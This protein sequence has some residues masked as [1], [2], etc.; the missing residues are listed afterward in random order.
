MLSKQTNGRTTM[1]KAKLGRTG[2][3]IT[4]LGLG[5]LPMGRAQANLSVDDGARVIRHAIDKGINFIDTAAS[6]GTYE[7]I[8]E[9]LKGYKG[10][11]IVASKTQA[12]TYEE[13]EE[14]VKD[15]LATLD[16]DNLDI[17][18][19]HAA[20]SVDPFRE[21]AEC[22]RYLIDSKRSGLVKAIGISTHVVDVVREALKIPEIDIIHPLINKASLGILGGSAEDM[23]N[24]AKEAH[25]AGKGI[26]VMKVYAGGHLTDDPVGAFTYLL[27]K[28]YLDA[29]VVGML[30]PEEVEI[31]LCIVEGRNP[32]YESVKAI[33]RTTK[34]LVVL[35]KLC[36]GC[37]NCIKTCPNGALSLVNGKST[38][39]SSACIL[40]GYCVPVCPQFCIRWA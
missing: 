9:G 15:A 26:Y 11:V 34:K 1:E 22:L 13:A 38:V 36:Q 25:R 37:G 19:V 24:A 23:L 31:N 5:T 16:R 28:P 6:Y 3:E 39:D 33:G 18:L 8:R 4:R 29:F 27:R 21:R 2:F 20:R 17:F 7:H 32:D 10:Q 14:D 30:K 40:C 35:S 12:T